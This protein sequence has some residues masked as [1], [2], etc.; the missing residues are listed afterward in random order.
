[1]RNVTKTFTYENKKQ[2]RKNEITATSKINVV[3]GV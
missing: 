3:E 1:M 2:K